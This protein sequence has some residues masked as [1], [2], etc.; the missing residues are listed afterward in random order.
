MRRRNDEYILNVAIVCCVLCV[1]CTYKALFF[2]LIHHDRSSISLIDLLKY[3]YKQQN[4]TFVI[5]SIHSPVL[6]R[7]KC[8]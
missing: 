8:V 3:Y 5:F 4:D 6:E 7:L 1:V 2:G